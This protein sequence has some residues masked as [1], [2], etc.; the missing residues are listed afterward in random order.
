M[1]GGCS[2][3]NRPKLV[4][5]PS[6]PATPLLTLITFKALP[7]GGAPSWRQPK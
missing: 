4:V 7:E 2:L 3:D 1:K 6:G 5:Q